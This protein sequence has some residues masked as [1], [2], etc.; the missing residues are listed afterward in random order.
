MERKEQEQA[1]VVVGACNIDLISYVPRFPSPGETLKGTKFQ[2]GFG[3]KGANQAVAVGLLGGRVTLIS[4]VGDDIFGVDTLRNLEGK[5]VGTRHVLVGAGVSTGC[6]P[7]LVDQSG[8]NAIVIIGGANDTLTDTELTD[9]FS[10][11]FPLASY[12]LCQLELPLHNTQHALFTAR[13][14]GIPTI[15]NTAPAVTLSQEILSHCTYLIAN[16]IEIFQIVGDS[17]P[18]RDEED[19]DHTVKAAIRILEMSGLGMKCVIVTLGSRGC[20]VV[21]RSDKE[22]ITPRDGERLDRHGDYLCHAIPAVR[23]ERVVDT[24]GAGDCFVGAFAH[25]LSEGK[26][27]I[28]SAR[29]AVTL[30][31]ISVQKEGT[32]SSYP[33]SL[34]SSFEW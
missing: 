32:Q 19:D 24:T 20:V 2:K 29:A 33:S 15:L 7:I 25:F 26:G 23:V 10:D 34:P 16:Q 1:V 30:A 4:K 13:S 9:A 6:A 5:G 11:V 3:G 21:T 14:R 31:A 28:R 18:L 8:E 27:V 12:V 17:P 22:E